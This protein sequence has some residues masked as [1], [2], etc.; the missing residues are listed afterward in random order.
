[1][2]PTLG[3]AAMAAS[4]LLACA[5][6]SSVFGAAMAAEPMPVTVGAYVNDIHHVDLG[7]HSFSIDLYVWFRWQSAKL[8][9]SESVE[10][11]NAFEQWGHTHSRTFDAPIRLPSGERYQVL[12]IQGRFSRKLDLSLFPFDRQ[13][14]R[15]QWEDSRSDGG[16]IQFVVDP[17]GVAIN[18]EIRLPGF[19]VQPPRLTID[20]MD[21]PT[22]FG[23]TREAI[24]RSTFDRVSL[25]VPVQ[26]PRFT[27]A[28]KYLIP[29]LC[30]IFCAALMFFFRP[31]HV[32][33]RVGIGITALLTL[34]ALQIT[35]NEDLPE[36]DYLVLMDKIYLGAYLFVIAGLATVVRTTWKMDG[37]GWNEA[38][39][40]RFDRRLL[41]GLTLAYSTVVI[42]LVGSAFH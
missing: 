25:V 3:R 32:D 31:S 5:L 36:I 21:Y 30:V 26:R 33:A 16:E 35:L 18:P 6:G 29:L 4:L 8:D 10:F 34:V 41:A 19:L 28:V 37:R 40:I 38:K 11:M 1:M 2:K 42:L 9:P 39:A 7:T 13:E 12:R 17:D 23:D 24:G 27:Y 22:R 20:S 14:L 15:V